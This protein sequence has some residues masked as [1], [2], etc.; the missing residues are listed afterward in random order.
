MVVEVEAALEAGAIGLSSGLIYAPGHPRRAARDRSPR[1]RRG[2][3]RAASTRPTCATRLPVCSLRS[4]RRSTAVRAGGSRRPAPGLAPQ[5]RIARAVWGRAD[6]AVGA[7]RRRAP[8]AWTSPPTSTRTRPPR[9]RWPSCCR[10]RCWASG[11]RSAWRRWPIATSATGSARRSSGGFRGWEN[12]ASD[13]G[14]SG[15]RISN[16]AS[17]PDWAGRSLADLGEELDRRPGRPRL[18]RPDRRPARRVDRHRLHA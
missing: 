17:H 7:S 2:P 11:S 12:V 14:W 15:I 13:P 18:R 1:Q 9:R 10:P 8:R 4:T 16:A 3:A 6:E 5:V